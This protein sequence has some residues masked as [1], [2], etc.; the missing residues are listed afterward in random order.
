MGKVRNLEDSQTLR[1]KKIG[2]KF[3]PFGTFLN[4]VVTKAKEVLFDFVC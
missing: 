4:P 3:S 1:K 2:N